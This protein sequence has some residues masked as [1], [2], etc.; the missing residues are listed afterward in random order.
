MM[1]ANVSMEDMADKRNEK[2][3]LSFYA[4]N[5]VI[6]DVEQIAT[7]LGPCVGDNFQMQ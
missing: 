1:L 7:Q 5:L 3:D 2:I 6:G 4:S